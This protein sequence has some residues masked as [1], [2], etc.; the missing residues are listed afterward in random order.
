MKKTSLSYWSIFALGFSM[1]LVLTLALATRGA[2]AQDGSFPNRPIRIVTPTAAGG[3]IDVMA[4][5]LAEKLGAA[6][7]QNV[8][9][10][11][12]PGAN[13]MIAASAV[14]KASPDGYTILFSHSALVQNLLLQPNPPYRL[15]ELAPVS[16]LALFPIAYAVNSSLGVNS[17]QELIAQAKAKPR[18]FSFGSYG[19]G[20]GGHI[21]GAGLNRAAGI[22][23]IHV[24]YKGEVPAYTDLMAGL[25]STA[26]GSVGYAARQLGSGKIKLLAVASLERLK[27]YP[28]VPTFT[29]AGFPG[30]NLP[31][32]GG[33]FLPAGTP[34]AII[35]RLNEETVKAVLSADLS[36]KVLAMGFV[37]VGSTAEAFSISIKNEMI[38]WEVAIRENQ[39]KLD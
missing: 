17:L 11:P 33:L 29:E 15:N 32:W 38:K 8:I 36:E 24:A 19:T 22:D 9:V 13:G 20:S 1:A 37:P 25:V 35:K 30:L 12:K 7:G 4:R 16:M 31:G 14:A 27:A 28:E 10:E 6:L 5:A 23:L 34:P 26:Y 21:I 2:L 3:N 39:I 18:T